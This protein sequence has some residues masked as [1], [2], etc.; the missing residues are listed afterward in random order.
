MPARVSWSSAG[1]GA[2]RRP[3]GTRDLRSPAGPGA[4]LAARRSA[5]AAADAL[6]RSPS[7]SRA[8]GGRIA[9][10][11]DE[12]RVAGRW[13]ANEVRRD[14]FLVELDGGRLVELYREGELWYVTGTAD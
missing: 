7:G 14:Y 13:W 5:G 8:S 9:R 12:W 10:V 11:V 3:A 2:S 4:E 6:A 1:D